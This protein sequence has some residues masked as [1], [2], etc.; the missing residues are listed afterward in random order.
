M[1]GAKKDVSQKVLAQYNIY[2]YPPIM[3]TL[4]NSGMMGCYYL[5][6]LKWVG[7]KSYYEPKQIPSI[8]QQRSNF[9]IEKANFIQQKTTSIE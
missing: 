2:E 3:L 4:S 9:T 6:N 8:N 1:E 7:Q 5:L